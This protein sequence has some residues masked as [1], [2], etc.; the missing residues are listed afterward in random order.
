MQAYMLA[1]E[2]N[3]LRSF[4]NRVHTLYF[5]ATPHRGADYS[6]A[7][8]NI[9]TISYGQK[10]FVSEL[11][12]D[13]TTI[14]SIND[15][16][17][18]Y[19][20]D[21][22][23]W[24]F[25][26]T[27]PTRVLGIQ[28][29]IVDATSAT[30]GFQN[31]TCLPLN[32]DHRGV[33]KFQVEN[34]SNYKT[35]RSSFTTSID[36]ISVDG[37]PG[38]IRVYLF[39]TTNKYLDSIASSRAK[40]LDL[41]QLDHLSGIG[42]TPE[43][44]LNAL[45][46][47][48][49][50]GTCEW[51]IKRHSY[52]TWQKARKEN[53]P[54]FWLAGNAGAG[55]SV[56]SSHV[57]TELRR[58]NLRCSHFFFKNGNSLKSS[59]ATCLRSLA[60]QMARADEIILRKVLDMQHN[61]SSWEHWDEKALWRKLFLGCIFKGISQDVHFWVIDS[62]DECQKNQ[63]L[64]SLVVDAPQ[65]LRIFFTS[66][67]GVH[68]EKHTS[69]MT[70][71]LEYYRMQSTDTLA[72]FKI[73][74]DTRLENVPAS[75]DKDRQDL[76]QKI[77]DKASGSF[78]WVSLVMNILANSY[79]EEAAEEIM[80]EVPT[81]MNSLYNEMLGNVLQ[82]RRAVVLARSLYMWTLLS[83]RPLKVD[84]LQVALKLDTNQ[85]VHN[86]EKLIPTISG[87]LVTV[88]QKQ[89]AEIIHQTAK[90]YLLQQDKHPDLALEKVQCHTQMAHICLG[91]LAGN[92]TET[93][94]PRTLPRTSA[95]F[96]S[97]TVADLADYA[98]EYF[99][100][101]L[102]RSYTDDDN[103]WDL[104]CRFLE[105][106]LLVW[107]EYLARKR[108]MHSVTR[109]AQNLR[110]YFRRRVKYLSPISPQRAS[111]ES[112]IYDLCRLSAK[113]GTSLTLSPSSIHHLIPSMCPSDSLISKYRSA[114]P[115]HTGFTMKG[116]V[117]SSW[118]DCLA[119]IDYPSLQTSAVACGDQYSAVALTNGKI[120]LYFQ[121]S[122]QPKFTLDHCGRAN[123]L[124]FS[125]EDRYLASSGQRKVRVW[126]PSE[127][128]LLWNFDPC[129]QVLGLS[130]IDNQCG[131]A[132]ATQANYVVKW[133]LNS[134]EEIDRWQWTDSIRGVGDTKRSWPQPGKA[135]FSP[136]HCFLAVNY[137]G[138][139]LHLFEASSKKFLGVFNRECESGPTGAINIEAFAFNT[140]SEINILIVSYADGE[141]V[142][143]DIDS[144]QL[145]YRRVDV[146]AHCL[147]CSPNGRTL[148]TG[149]SKGTIRIFEFAGARGERLLPLY[150]INAQDDGIR[151]IGFSSDSTRFADIRGSQYRVWE[152]AVLGYSDIDEGSQSE[153]S[154]PVSVEMKSI[155]MLDGASE[156]EI[157]A[158]CCHASGYFVFYGK[159]DGSVSYFETS[160]AK[161]QQILYRHASNIGVTCIL[162]VEKQELLVTADES[163][164]V[165]INKL[166]ASNTGFDFCCCIA[167][168]RSE[169]S[170]SQLL[171]DVSGTRILLRGTKS[172]D[173]W[174]IDGKNL[175][176]TLGNIDSE[177]LL[178]NDPL[179]PGY[180]AAIGR[181]D[182]R[183]F[184]WEDGSNATIKQTVDLMIT[185]PT[186][187]GRQ[188]VFTEEAA[189]YCHEPWNAP[190]FVSLFR[191]DIR[192][193]PQYDGNTDTI[194][195]WPASSIIDSTCLPPSIPLGTFG[196]HARRV[197]Q[198]IGMAGSIL[199]F[200]DTDL[201]ICSLDISNSSTIPDGAKRHFFL[202]SEWRSIDGGFLVEYISASREFVVSKKHELLVISGGL[203]LEQPWMAKAN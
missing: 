113:F 111:M 179:R 117:D 78:L 32:A 192:Y 57:V 139:P 17:R 173:I 104:L 194:R 174:T 46:D 25:Y 60:N 166:T 80:E 23:L 157:T 59:L 191:H 186:P 52:I 129:H 43:D 189:I 31:E 94:R 195:I 109:T 7:L 45:E 163:G 3:A 2:D 110:S 95:S 55:K 70:G 16:F 165:I 150:T 114:S 155:S 40:T 106:N 146:F 196:C 108:S 50:P 170:V 112:W 107:I 10:T 119:R 87:Q 67:S 29:I 71:R 42:E 49:A 164:R 159:R 34:D 138:L 167:E 1:R 136:D 203:E 120:N 201:W 154:H 11:N 153:L 37:K 182:I 68:S 79:S 105:C 27:D 162:Y 18:H 6:K 44:E 8:A 85:T 123:I 101:H 13:S 134:G 89:E 130:F 54:F 77:L 97:S 100:D 118:D 26:E 28:A 91:I 53:R 88:N 96:V 75:R 74:I 22:Q 83:S 73:F 62:V 63:S 137:R 168:I 33:C 102:Q 14:A 175:G 149:N 184:A 39:I 19:A 64:L 20:G 171:H 103:N 172:T 156:P 132:G 190:F 76:K 147:K 58:N 199:L 148:I 65:W 183:I 98:C 82:N 35:L 127:G 86:L 92:S 141:L 81:D 140:S 133:D 38:D 47:T 152:P 30:L 131:L 161:H 24:S 126:D 180:L 41:Q 61:S 185:P 200:L 56:L 84:G 5:L 125:N 122:G 12:R 36:R 178:V 124:I 69:T 198:I 145:R 177:A 143:Y 181:Q 128:V 197:R 21:L 135:V 187:T 188:H 90:S 151:D 93:Q 72:D 115:L 99:S 121:E 142:V 48:R 116:I 15:S 66:R 4:A 158:L 160:S 169:Q 9:L 193:P 176:M 202:L 144:T 51:L